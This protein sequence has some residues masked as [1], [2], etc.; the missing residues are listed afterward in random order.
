MYE[1]HSTRS[2]RG[3]CVFVVQFPCCSEGSSR[4]LS[5]STMDVV[6]PAMVEC[7]DL[8]ARDSPRGMPPA[9]HKQGSV[10]CIW[11]QHGHTNRCDITS[12]SVLRWCPC[13][14]RDMT[15]TRARASMTVPGRPQAAEVAGN[16]NKSRCR[17][18]RGRH[19]GVGAAERGRWVWRKQTADAARTSCL[20]S[21]GT[22]TGD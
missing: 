2:L 22:R 15:R 13:R 7:L 20:F 3:T 17:G 5:L 6:L 12:P 14:P 1:L 16:G 8:D 10:T 4:A 18:H 21:V 9:A 11:Q 19:Q